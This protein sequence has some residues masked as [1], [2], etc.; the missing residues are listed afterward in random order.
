MRAEPV[1][2]KNVLSWIWFLT[3]GICLV[4]LIIFGFIFILSLGPSKKKHF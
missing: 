4:F 1:D 3:K 2:W